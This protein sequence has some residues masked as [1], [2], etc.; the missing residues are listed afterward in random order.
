LQAATDNWNRTL[1][2]T[3]WSVQSDTVNLSGAVVTITLN[4]T[5]Q[6]VTVTQLASGYGSDYAID[7]LPSGW[8]MAAGNTYHVAITGIATPIA[9]DVQVVSCS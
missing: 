2:T 9:Y 5:T 8:K 4:G 6:P 1:D 7:I 3:G